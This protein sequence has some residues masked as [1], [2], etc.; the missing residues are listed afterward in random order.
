MEPFQPVVD[1]KFK[2]GSIYMKGKIPKDLMSRIAKYYVQPGTKTIRKKQTSLRMIIIE[3]PVS[4][5][6]SYKRH[7]LTLNLFL[8]TE[9]HYHIAATTWFDKFDYM[10]FDEIP[11]SIIEDIESYWDEPESLTKLLR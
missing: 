9:D 1:E 6:L 2:I 3:F 5:G 10:G 7:F 4:K 8:V 11:I